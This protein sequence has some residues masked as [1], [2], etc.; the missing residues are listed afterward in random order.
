MSK[1]MA[2]L[3]PAGMY[4]MSNNSL[5]TSSLP[6]V[7]KFLFYANI[8]K[9]SSAQ[10]TVKRPERTSQAHT[11]LSRKPNRR[12]GYKF[13]SFAMTTAKNKNSYPVP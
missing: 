11:P 5:V 9:G 13:L 1:N 2:H 6:K 3:P 8:A 4:K 10:L 7:S 12:E